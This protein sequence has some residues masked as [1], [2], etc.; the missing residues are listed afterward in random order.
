M[1]LALLVVS[2]SNLLTHSTGEVVPVCVLTTPGTAALPY[3]TNPCHQ[4]TLSGGVMLMHGFV[5]VMKHA[6]DPI[7]PN[8]ARSS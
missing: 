3:T 7:V 2:Q 5:L 6:T 8:Y 4:W 1:C